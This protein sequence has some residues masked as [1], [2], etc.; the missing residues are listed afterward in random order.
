[1]LNV[2]LTGGLATGKS[3]VARELERLGC[4]I[5]RLD[6]IGHQL[7][8]PGGE[9]F[10]A[11]VAAFGPGILDAHGAIDRR[12]LGR[13]VFA[14]P[15][16]LERLNALLH[17]LIRA[18]AQALR[19]EFARTDPDGILVTEAAILIETGSY[20]DYDCLIVTVCR[21]E[22]QLERALA[23][24]AWT[25]AEAEQRLARQLP[26]AQK[27]RYA[28]YVIDTSG[29]EESTREQTRRVWRLLR[30]RIP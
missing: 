27:V 11:V 12:A 3:V 19:E 5:I 23:R 29:T 22:Q 13:R 20:R 15:E 25:R 16:E 7:L 6:E 18:R 26:A 9:A 8:E 2:G 4:R 1:M 14:N 30:S 10:S 21:P 24:G 28:D 17:P